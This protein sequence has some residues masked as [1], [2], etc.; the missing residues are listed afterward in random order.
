MNISGLVNGVNLRSIISDSQE[1]VN[2]T[3]QSL[4]ENWRIIEQNIEYSSLVSETLRNIFFYLDVEKNLKIPGTNVSKIDVVYFNENTI[5][6]NM[7]SEQP[8]GFCG[9]PDNCSCAYQSVVE[10]VDRNVRKWQVN[11]GEIVKN[12]HD[13]GGIFGVNVITNAVSSNE[14]C[15]ST[16]TKEEYTTISLM[17]SED[18]KEIHEEVFDKIE[19]Y[20][21]DASIFKHD[22]TYIMLKETIVKIKIKRKLM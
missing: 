14:K 1:I 17:K 10:I 20:L 9:L 19:G 7:Y 5:R 15:T 12:F 13:P 21:K 3:L 18:S 2:K 11:P 4:E 16:R 8:G 22:G 6:L